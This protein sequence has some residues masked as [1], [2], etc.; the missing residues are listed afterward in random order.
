MRMYF[1][2]W[3][4]SACFSGLWG[5]SWSKSDLFDRQVKSYLFYSNNPKFQ[6]VDYKHLKDLDANWLLRATLEFTF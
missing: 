3:A 5:N 4:P 6:S 1:S 2:S